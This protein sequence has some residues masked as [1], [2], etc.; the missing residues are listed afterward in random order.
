[1]LLFRRKKKKKT[2]RIRIR[3]KKK[4]IEFDTF[5]LRGPKSILEN[6]R[7]ERVKMHY[8]CGNTTFMNLDENYN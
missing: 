4:Y 8:F 6:S 1:M 2:E 5:K 3:G 7:S